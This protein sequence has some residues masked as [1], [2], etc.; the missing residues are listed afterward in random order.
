[1]QTR[2]SQTALEQRRQ[3]YLLAGF[4]FPDFLATGFFI[5]FF[6]VV[7]GFAFVIFFADFFADD[8]A[9]DLPVFE[10]NAFL[11]GFLTFTS[12]TTSSFPPNISSHF[13]C[14]VS[15]PAPFRAT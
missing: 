8:L 2:R 10:A 6:T 7:F 5:T 9:V 3:G 4:F 15:T 13:A 11:R 14:M 12:S 1:M